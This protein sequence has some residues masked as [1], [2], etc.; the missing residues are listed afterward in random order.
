VTRE[1][2]RGADLGLQAGVDLVQAVGRA[3]DGG[4]EALPRRRVGGGEQPDDL[5]LVLGHRQG[6]QGS[7]SAGREE[8]GG[9][10]DEERPHDCR[11]GQG[12]DQRGAQQPAHHTSTVPGRAGTLKSA[13]PRGTGPRELSGPPAPR[14]SPPV[15]SG[16][17]CG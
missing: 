3:A 14:R 12:G 9:P 7:A 17:P 5:A 10:D 8:P 2:L 13:P 1:G 11:G 15:D 16:A 6:R 4:D